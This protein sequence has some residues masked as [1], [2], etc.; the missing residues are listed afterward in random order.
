MDLEKSLKLKIDKISIPSVDDVKINI[1]I[2]LSK[3]ATNLLLVDSF[4]GPMPQRFSH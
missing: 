1:N 4:E 3:W 2:R